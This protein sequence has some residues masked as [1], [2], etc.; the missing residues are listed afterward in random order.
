MT[1]VLTHPLLEACG[2]R[3]GFGT[4]DYLASAEILRP[5]QVHGSLVA[6]IAASGKPHPDEADAIVASRRSSPGSTIGVVTADCVPLLLAT[7]Q[8]EW[9]AASHA[10][11][12][13]LAQG[14]IA[15]ALQHLE[16]EGVQLKDARCVIGPH[17]G[18][19]CYEVDAPVY[20]AMQGAFGDRATT[21]FERTRP[22]HW[23]VAL[24]QLVQQTLQFAGI[25]PGHIGE[26]P[27]TCTC[28]HSEVFHSYRREGAASGRLVHFIQV[29]EP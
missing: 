8:G 9:V 13:G 11:W 26:L 20:D 3:H 1:S 18:P 4:R 19:C 16:R 28:C 25:S 12:R 23:K 10:G 5:K 17:I 22:G 2:V 29:P 27:D 15:A 21:A 14:V 7:P 6:E 24:G